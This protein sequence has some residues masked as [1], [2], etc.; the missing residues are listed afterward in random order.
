MESQ[1]ADL[2]NF[3]QPHIPDAPYSMDIACP[4]YPNRRELARLSQAYYYF[5]K[6]GV[7]HLTDGSLIC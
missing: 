1:P 4:A 2:C 7:F 6:F 5:F 3:L